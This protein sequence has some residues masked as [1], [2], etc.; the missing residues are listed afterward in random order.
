MEPI[1]VL[2][3]DCTGEIK[4]GVLAGVV[5]YK[6][7]WANVTE[8]GNIELNSNLLNEYC[9]LHCLCHEGQEVTS[10]VMMNWLGCVLNNYIGCGP[11]VLTDYL[12]MAKRM[13]V[14]WSHE[15]I[16]IKF[17]IDDTVIGR[18]RFFPITIDEDTYAPSRYVEVSYPKTFEEA[19]SLVKIYM[20]ALVSEAGI[21]VTQTTLSIEKN[22]FD[23]M[24]KEDKKLFD[25]IEVGA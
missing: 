13:G 3:Y 4:K 22:L 5:Q 23:L 9:D 17:K 25:H 20:N 18:H 19:L 24:T 6:P 21:P 12:K 10:V 16:A 1:K 7:V 8:G 14:Q 15:P 11:E 2:F